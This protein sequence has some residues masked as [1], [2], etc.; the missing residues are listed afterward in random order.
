M[1]RDPFGIKP[2]YYSLMDD[3]FMFASEIKAFLPH[4]KFKK[5]LNEKIISSYLCFN[6]NPNEET[7]FKGVFKLNPGTYLLY[8]DDELTKERYFKFELEEKEED[9]NTI[10]DNIKKSM[11]NSVSHHLIS[12]VSV[13]SFLS[14]GIDSSYLVS[15]SK[16]K[17]TYTVGY[18]NKNYDE[19]SSKVR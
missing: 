4:P 10:I 17:N 1:A 6:S 5:E 15:T 8:K 13:G 7:F 3:T 19:I 11:N 14:S 9:M 18:E 2:L 16:V 12:D